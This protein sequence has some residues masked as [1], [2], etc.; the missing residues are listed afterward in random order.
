MA[1][2]QTAPNLPQGGGI[3]PPNLNQQQINEYFTVR[4]DFN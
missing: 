3:L 4:F 1:S 2:V